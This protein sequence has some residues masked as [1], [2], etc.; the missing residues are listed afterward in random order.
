MLVPL[1]VDNEFL[2]VTGSDIDLNT[3]I[4]F[5]PV[6]DKEKHL[7]V[8]DKKGQL[9]AH[10]SLNPALQASYGSKD[11]TI[12]TNEFVNPQLQAI[13]N[14]AITMKLPE[15]ANSFVQNDEAHIINIRKI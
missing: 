7:L 5:L 11:K 9:L 1:Y 12:T 13:I 14:E 15:Y 6:G 3:L 10:P 8:F 2:G 4:S